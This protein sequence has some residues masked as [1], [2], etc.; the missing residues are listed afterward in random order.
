MKWDCCHV[1]PQSGW[2]D[3]ASRPIWCFYALV[4]SGRVLTGIDPGLARTQLIV[5]ILLMYSAYAAIGPAASGLLVVMA[6][7]V[8]YAMFMMKAA[9]GVVPGRPHAGRIGRDDGRMRRPVA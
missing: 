1:T 6:S 8:V 9:P 5:G 4:R 2:P 7:H 3:S